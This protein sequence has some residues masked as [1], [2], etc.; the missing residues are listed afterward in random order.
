[1]NDNLEEIWA[2]IETR[3]N[4]KDQYLQRMVCIE[5]LYR[6]YIGA[7]GIPS[8]RFLSIEIPEAEKEKFVSFSV[9]KGFR[10]KTAD[11]EVKHPGYTTCVLEAA[12]SEQNDVFTIVAKDILIELHKYND[13]ADYLNALKERISKWEDF[14]KR[15]SSQLLSDIAVIG[16]IGELTFILNM[17]D[18]GINSISD[19]WNGP[20]KSAQDFQ[21][22]SVAIEVKTTSANKIE[23][24]N[25]SSEIQLNDEDGRELYLSVFRVERNDATGTRLPQFVENV[26]RGLNESQKGS[27]DAKLMCLGYRN[28]DAEKY[29]KG[30]NVKDNKNYLVVDGFPRIIPEDLPHDIF[31]VKYKIN[32]I[33][34]DMFLTEMENIVDSIKENE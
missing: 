19:Y 12:S 9:P 29:I 15:A 34:C 10:L 16:L 7:I 21:S 11:Y 25:I 6:T 8:H 3:I 13:E 20:I 32:L 27:F 31:D 5:L 2:E 23:A 24:V 18:E 4:S 22:E 28:E 26:R 14:F 17:Q 30:Y 33:N 1:M